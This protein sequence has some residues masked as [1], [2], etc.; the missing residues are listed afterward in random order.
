[1][2]EQQPDL[3]LAM[4]RGI[5]DVLDDHTRK[6]DEVILRLDRLEREVASLHGDFAGL[7]LLTDVRAP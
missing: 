1:V 6:F 2:S 4:F 5:R 7:S 3:V